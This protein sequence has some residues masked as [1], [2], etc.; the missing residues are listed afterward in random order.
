MAG[1]VI[2]CLLLQSDWTNPF[3]VPKNWLAVLAGLHCAVSQQRVV[4]GD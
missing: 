1:C 2:R 3:L 4:Q